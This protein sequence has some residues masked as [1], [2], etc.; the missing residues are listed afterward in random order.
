[1]NGGY[2][3]ALAAAFGVAAAMPPALA[4]ATSSQPAPPPSPQEAV[5][6]AG[7]TPGEVRKVDREQGKV[8]LRHG[9]IR[10]L[11]MPPM[12]MVFRVA[13]PRLL[14]Q[15]KPGDQVRFRAENRNGAYTVIALERAP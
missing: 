7:L 10:D 1:M 14:E 12:T 3:A 9:E 15:L 6:D 13:D 11:G 5:A 4:Q 2:L 8:T